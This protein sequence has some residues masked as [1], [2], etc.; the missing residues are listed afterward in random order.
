MKKGNILLLFPPTNY[1]IKASIEGRGNRG[2]RALTPPLGLLYLSAELLD[3]GYNVEVV[4]FTAQQYSF[5]TLK[6]FALDKDVVGIMV[7]SWNR[8]AAEEIIVNVRR[9]RQDIPIMVGGPDCIL[10][11]RMLDNADVVATGEAEHTIVSIVDALINEKDLADCE[12]ILFRDETTGEV[13]EGKPETVQRDLDRIKF[14]ARHIVPPE[15]YTMLG[16][17]MAGK[18]ALVLASRGCPYSC[19]FC[20]RGAVAYKIYRKRSAENVLDEIQ[21]IY[22]AGYKVL[23]F[24]D[25]NF[26]LDRERVMRIM[27][28]IIERKI[29]IPMIVQGRVESADAELYTTMRKAGI[30]GIIFGLESGNQDVLDF[31]NKKSTVEQNRRAVE[32]ANR[33]GLF[34]F[35]F[36]ILGSPIET[37][38]HLKRTVAFAKNTPL[39]SATFYLLDYTYGSQLWDEAHAKGLIEEH[40]FNVIACKKRGLSQFTREELEKFCLEAFDSF[41][42]RPSLWARVGKKIITNRDVEALNLIVRG[43]MRLFRDFIG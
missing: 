39:D 6:K 4:D 11:R 18:F 43:V 14:P 34:T 12:G 31:Y 23:G 24:V 5:D 15:G 28:G 16:N 38:E 32:I 37:E 40:E 8:E 3:A 20:A 42:R 36:F 25:D 10:H 7:Q 9:I 17:D 30:R 2:G 26:L 13:R 19:R 1:Q 35:G 21:E 29:H 33:C 22:D 41:Y 27:N